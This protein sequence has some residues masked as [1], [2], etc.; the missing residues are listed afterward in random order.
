M[1][2]N[3]GKWDVIMYLR[4]KIKSATGVNS[5]SLILT[6]FNLPWSATLKV[7]KVYSL[8]ALKT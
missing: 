3:Q 7:L 6:E 4:W 2:E 5:S 1:V 8:I